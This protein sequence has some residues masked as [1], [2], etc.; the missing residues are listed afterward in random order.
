MTPAL[1]DLYTNYNCK[2]PDDVT[3]APDDE[4][5]VTCDQDGAAKYILG[6]VEVSGSGISNA[7][8]GLATDSQGA[9][10]GSGRST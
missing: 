1:Q 6:P 4:P 2:A 10:T 5:L 3:T 9:T 7:T 8:S